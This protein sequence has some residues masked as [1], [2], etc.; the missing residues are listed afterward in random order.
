ML[1]AYKHTLASDCNTEKELRPR[2]NILKSSNGM[3]EKINIERSEYNERVSGLIFPKV[4]NTQQLEIARNTAEVTLPINDVLHKMR[5][6]LRP[7]FYFSRTQILSH[8]N[9]D[10]VGTSKM[11]LR[12]DDCHLPSK[13]TK[14]NQ[15]RR[16]F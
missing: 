6:V 9:L 15:R 12:G 16:N 4:T 14:S 2:E 11:Q 13:T 7:F 3:H 1:S 8:T 5:T 10:C